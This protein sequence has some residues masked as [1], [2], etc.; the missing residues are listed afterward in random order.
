MTDP[1]I[2]KKHKIFLSH[3]G[4]TQGQSFMQRMQQDQKFRTVFQ[5]AVANNLQLED[6]KSLMPNENEAELDS[7]YKTMT[8][9]AC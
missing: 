3:L 2:Q 9:P 7:L 1:Y 5:D 6:L 8:S 4:K